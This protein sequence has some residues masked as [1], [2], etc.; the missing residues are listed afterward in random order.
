MS[1]GKRQG[2]VDELAAIAPQLCAE[3]V[4]HWA[5]QPM[6]VVSVNCLEQGCSP[7]VWGPFCSEELAKEWIERHRPQIEQ[8][9]W[10]DM[11]SLSTQPVTR[12]F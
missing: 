3:I 9:H 6:Y 11:C 2:F 5:K 10:V 1:N 8:L 12:E 7:W 4:S